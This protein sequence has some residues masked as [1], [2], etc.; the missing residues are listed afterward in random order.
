MGEERYRRRMMI[1]GLLDSI[2]FIKNYDKICVNLLMKTWAELAEM[3]GLPDRE[4]IRITFGGI[5]IPNTVI[6]P[7]FRVFVLVRIFCI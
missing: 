6:K 1:I 7:I 4:T 2:K 5:E 3:R